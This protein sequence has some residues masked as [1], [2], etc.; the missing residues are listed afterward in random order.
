M[1]YNTGKKWKGMEK[2]VGLH[3]C[4]STHTHHPPSVIHGP[5]KGAKKNVGITGCWKWELLNG[6]KDPAKLI[7]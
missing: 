7:Y 1:Q 4:K 2:G 5:I 6:P 3:C